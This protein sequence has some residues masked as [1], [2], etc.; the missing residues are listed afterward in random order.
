MTDTACTTAIRNL[1]DGRI[2]DARLPSNCTV[3]DA[4]RAIDALARAHDAT[5]SLGCRPRAS[6]LARD[7][8][9]GRR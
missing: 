6:A 8:D 2:A 9:W 1:A 3:A 4:A 7:R 5:G